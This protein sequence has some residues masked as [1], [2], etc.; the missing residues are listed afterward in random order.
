MD[1]AKHAAMRTCHFKNVCFRPKTSEFEYYAHPHLDPPVA[2]TNNSVGPLGSLKQHVYITPSKWGYVQPQW[3]PHSFKSVPGP[4][5]VAPRAVW[6]PKQVTVVYEDASGGNYGHFIGDTLLG[7]FWVQSVF[8]LASA[9]NQVVTIGNPASTIPWFKRLYGLVA[10]GVSEFPVLTMSRMADF[11]AAGYT[12]GETELLC[13]ENLLAG[14]GKLEFQRDD[15][16][17]TGFGSVYVD[18]RNFVLCNFGLDPTLHDAARHVHG[19][20]PHP[21]QSHVI[22]YYQHSGRRQPQRFAEAIEMIRKAFPSVQVDM[23]DVHASQK[24]QLQQMQRSTVF[25]A[26][27]GG[28]SFGG[29]FLPEGSAAIVFDNSDSVRS[30][31]FGGEAR[32]WSN[33]PTVRDLYYPVLD[34]DVVIPHDPEAAKLRYIYDFQRIRLVPCR[35][36]RLVGD[37]L[38]H[39]SFTFNLPFVDEQGSHLDELCPS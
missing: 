9:N 36:A 35:L 28:G 23:L 20:G 26:G 37:A 24:A 22:T 17:F 4:V 13:F 1:G 31:R 7:L 15:G 6:S 19:K 32:M 21:I 12:E 14:N 18:F 29:L 27:N 30:V 11:N 38:N 16:E 34:E 25:V 39:A 33:L 5:P 8:G 10:P 3:L 2:F